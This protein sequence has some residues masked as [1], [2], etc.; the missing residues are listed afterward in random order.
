M[1]ELISHETP[2]HEPTAL[3]VWVPQRLIGRDALLAKVYTALKDNQPVQIYGVSGIG[4]TA[5]AATLA[6][7]YTEQ[8]GGVLWLNVEDSSLDEL[9]VRVGRAYAVPDIANSEIPGAMVGAVAS[10]LTQ[11]KPL[12]VLDGKISRAVI[13]EF[14]QRCVSN[15]PLLLVSDSAVHEDWVSI[16]IG[17]L[18]TSQ[19]ALLLAQSA[20]LPESP[21]EHVTALATA[22]QRVPLAL[23]IAGANLKQAKQ[24]PENYLG[25][26]QQIPGAS[27]ANPNLLALTA[28]FRSQNSALQGILLMMGATFTRGASIEM[29]SEISNAPTETLR[30][31]MNLLAQQHLVEQSSRNGE[32]Y[33]SLHEATYQFAQ[34]WLRGS[35]RLDDLQEK[36]KS[37]AISYAQKHGADSP[38]YDKLAAE[39]PSFLAIGRWAA[40]QKDIDTPNQIA[41]ALMAA[42]DFISERGYVYELLQLRR[43]AASST[44]AFPAHAPEI[45]PSYP[46]PVYEAFTEDEDSGI[47]DD[48]DADDNGD[49][50]S[51]FTAEDDDV[52]EVVASDSAVFVPY[53]LED[54][55]L[56]EKLDDEDD[57]ADYD[58][59]DDEDDSDDSDLLRSPGLPL[60]A[61]R[62]TTP[63][64]EDLDEL[65][66]DPT[67]TDSEAYARLMPEP[68]PDSIE[69]LRA[70]L[71]TAR[72]SGNRRKQ[73]ELLMALGYKQVED[74]MENEALASYGE[75]LNVYEEP[76]MEEDLLNALDTVSTL[77]VRTHNAQAAILH[78]TRGIQLATQLQDDDTRMHLLIT[79][80]NARQA[81]GESDDAERAYSQALEI[82]RNRDD[83]QNEALILYKLGYAQLDN[84][85]PEAASATWE[86]AL[87]LFRDQNKRDYEGR[88]M[89]GLGSAYSEL[90]RWAEAISFHTSA[91]YIAREVHDKE[92]EAQQLNNLGYAAVQTEKLGDAVL[93]YR[94]ALH[95]AYEQDDSDSIVSTIVDLV[96]LLVKSPRHLKIAELLINDAAHYEPTDRDVVKL[97]DRIRNE[98]LMEE[99]NGSPQANVSGTARDYAENA[100]ALLDA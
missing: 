20:G 74:S 18:E 67:E 23:L 88:V 27:S 66:E 36:V 5:L 39:M 77:A 90:D 99:A 4:K 78:A 53:P 75:A 63:R 56:D 100:Y 42:D 55:D 17:P 45:P 40:G 69:G 65:D 91:L 32:T 58:E 73:G 87:Q 49:S 38:D 48:D 81:L 82:A 34:T 97:Q 11:H 79:L 50:E 83:S 3:P 98:I 89:G 15:L 33:Y 12:L 44:S 70:Q 2:A 24:D 60:T 28:A 22:L 6:A 57:D 59:E 47:Y 9:I 86:Q 19:A 94:Q 95:L 29:L 31:V 8:P 43:L 72:Q 14:V 93:R 10:T 80:G 26:L 51:L 41:N 13:H 52:E 30:Q 16:E 62:I 64:P 85:D 25:L 76:G 37:A 92:E 35:K 61:S 54:L 68:L 1:A 7:A 71:I 96:S 46:R 84:S 21:D